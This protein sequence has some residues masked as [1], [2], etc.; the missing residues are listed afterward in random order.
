M[1]HTPT[2]DMES[3]LCQFL[4][5]HIPDLTKDEIDEIVVSYVTGIL[6]DLL[7]SD[8]D[9][10]V[11]DAPA[12]HE[13]LTAYVPPAQAIGL[14]DLTQWIMSQAQAWQDEATE[15]RRQSSLLNIRAVIQDTVKT[16]V[17]KREEERDGPPEDNPHDK[18]VHR[19]RTRLSETSDGMS[20]GS[21]DDEEIQ[22]TVNHLLEMFPYSCSLEVNHCL[23]LMSGDIERTAQLIM[24]RYETGQNFKSSD[25]K[26]SRA[27]KAVADDKTIKSQILGRYGF[28]DKVVDARYHRPIIKKTDEKKLI[29]YRD[30]KIV[31]TKGERFTQVSKQ[32][33]EEMKKSIVNIGFYQ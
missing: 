13:M 31:S 22:Q 29:R 11:L 16:A 17:P 6:E 12:L 4:Q 30:G 25:R 27:Q 9:E 5:S 28:V 7:T 32:E 18:K 1:A 14:S 23:Q 26:I 19:L 33:S 8:L 10:D 15:K 3:A 20:E 2:R 24:H 21:L